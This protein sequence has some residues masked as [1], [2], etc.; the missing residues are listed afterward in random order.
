[1][2][3][4]KDT[5]QENMIIEDPKENVV[6]DMANPITIMMGVTEKIEI[7][8]K[9]EAGV[10]VD[11]RKGT[12]KMGMVTDEEQKIIENREETVK[13]RN[14]NPFGLFLERFP[15]F[16][17]LIIW[18]MISPVVS[19]GRYIKPRAPVLQKLLSSYPGLS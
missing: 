1:M 19:K 16:I 17:P 4:H 5:L 15:S 7:K 3:T 10:G 13:C 14:I 11:H 12:P 18:G 2:S 6:D 9:L 8:A